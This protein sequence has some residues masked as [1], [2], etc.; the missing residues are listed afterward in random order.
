MDSYPRIAY[1]VQVTVVSGKHGQAQ[2]AITHAL[3]YSERG[4]RHIK[5]GARRWFRVTAV[6]LNPASPERLHERLNGTDSG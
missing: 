1:I 2:N 6:R 4:R 5:V 3:C